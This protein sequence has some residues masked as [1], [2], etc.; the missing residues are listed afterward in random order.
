MRRRVLSFA[1]LA[2]LTCAGLVIGI[3]G[4]RASRAEA[5]VTRAEALLLAPLG[6]APGWT[7]V[8]AT[9][10]A[11]LLEEAR[12]AGAEGPRVEG[13]A[14]FAQALADAQRGSFV[15]AEAPLRQAMVR[16]GGSPDLKVLAAAIAR[17]RSQRERAGLLLDEVLAARPEHGRARLLAADLALDAGDGD[18]AAAHLDP[19]P[20]DV[21]AVEDRRGLAA[22]LRADLGAALQRYRRAV[23]LDPERATAWVNLGRLQRRAGRLDEARRAFDRALAERPGDPDAH[24]GRGLARVALG[25][26]AGAEADFLRAA[27]GAPNDA[28]PLLALGDLR[29]DLGALDAAASTYR[30]ALHRED[31]DAAS[32]LKLGNVLTLLR[33]YRAAAASFDEA[34]R[35]APTLAAAH[36]G[37][38][39]ALMHLGDDEAAREELESAAALDPSDPNPLMNL[40]V[41]HERRG[42]VREARLAFRQA[43]ARDPDSEAARRR[44]ARL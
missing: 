22:E 9:R 29:R 33:D 32:W 36:N 44:L 43:L 2:T 5:L 15:L 6:E 31:A 28:E 4:R 21:G 37:R 39:A 10:A 34:L 19:L 23:E 7:E 20:D 18:A 42:D 25:D 26:L 40:G 17:G 30:E 41:L 24:L 27:R 13:L 3:Q 11:A 38:G 12:E 16:L 14:A 35:R 1:V 8:D